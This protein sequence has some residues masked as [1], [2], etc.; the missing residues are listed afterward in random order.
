MRFT[1]SFGLLVVAALV[2]LTW[3]QRRDAQS[4]PPLLLVCGDDGDIEALCSTRRPEDLE[5]T[6]DGKYLPATQFLSQG[7]GSSVGGG[8]A[9]FDLEFNSFRRKT[10]SKALHEL[11]RHPKFQSQ[12]PAVLKA[13][14]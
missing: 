9:L 5:L 8:M 6:P 3:A 7:R 2:S 10:H 1:L 14:A 12:K 11:K 4:V 13:A